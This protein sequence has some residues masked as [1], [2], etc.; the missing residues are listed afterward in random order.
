MQDN[1]RRSASKPVRTLLLSLV[2]ATVPAAAQAQQAT[3]TGKV[4][5]EGN[6]PVADARVFLVGT[7]SGATTN[8]DGVYTLRGVPAGVAEVRVLRVGY[9]EQKKSV[10]VTTGSSATLDFTLTAA[11][12]QLQE[13]V[14]T[15][16]GNR[17]STPAAM[18]TVGQTSIPYSRPRV[19]CR[20]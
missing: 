17:S 10:Q 7:T 20:P 5:A 2:I 19:S 12:V 13:I 15:A 16:T 9:R 8:Q 6:Q 14:T 18:P 4:T 3:I 11:V 1:G